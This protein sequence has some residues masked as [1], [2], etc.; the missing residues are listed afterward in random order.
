MLVCADDGSPQVQA[1]VFGIC[2]NP[3]AFH[4]HFVH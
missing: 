1:E 3:V 4:E 2:V